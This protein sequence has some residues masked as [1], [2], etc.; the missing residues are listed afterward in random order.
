[1]NYRIVMGGA[2]WTVEHQMMAC[3]AG[4]QDPEDTG[5]SVNSFYAVL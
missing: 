3:I 4:I 1:M 5:F 2:W